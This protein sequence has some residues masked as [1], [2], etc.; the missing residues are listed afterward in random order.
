M[1]ADTPEIR[2][3]K[4]NLKEKQK[5]IHTILTHDPCKRNLSHA[6]TSSFSDLFNSI[7]HFRDK[8]WLKKNHT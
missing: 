7:L 6:N 3:K 2:V 8:V 1:G 5:M 4:E